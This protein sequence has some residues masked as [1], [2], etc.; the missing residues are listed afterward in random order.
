M[1]CGEDEAGVTSAETAAAALV[2][3]GY[4]LLRADDRG[5]DALFLF[6]RALELGPADGDTAARAWHGVGVVFL[7]Q[8]RDAEA[9]SA[10]EHAV[11]LQPGHTGARYNLGVLYG[12]AGNRRA[13]LRQY[14]ALCD[15]DPDR[16]E[17]LW[18]QIGG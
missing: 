5:T 6:R 11:R 9:I 14:R 1:P 3:V 18:T 12:L 4:E 2:H 7:Y 8:Q 17:L 15:R 10:F 13:A 16:A